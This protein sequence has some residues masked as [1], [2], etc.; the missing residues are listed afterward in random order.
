MSLFHMVRLFSYKNLAAA[1]MTALKER[2]KNN[3]LDSSPQITGDTG[4]YVW[5]HSS[6]ND[7]PAFATGRCKLE[8][9]ISLLGVAQKYPQLFHKGCAEGADKGCK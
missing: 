3:D 9:P 4:A 1:V 8:F 5:E 2:D 6:M 7:Y